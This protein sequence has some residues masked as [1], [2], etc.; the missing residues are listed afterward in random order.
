MPLYNAVN[1]TYR[2]P[3]GISGDVQATVR[4][5]NL[6]VL[7]CPSDPDWLSNSPH[8]I[9]S[10]NRA[11]NYAGNVGSE[12]EDYPETGV[13]T[14][15]S[16]GPRDITDGLSQTAG[17]SEWII[18]RGTEF[19]DDTGPNQRG[20]LLG[21][22][23]GIN[24]ES[25]LPDGL[26]AF[27][28]ACTML[29]IGRASVL[30][31]SKGTPWMDSSVGSS[32]YNHVLPPNSPSCNYISESPGSDVGPGTVFFARSAGSRHGG[33][34]QSLLLDG[35]VRFVKSSIDRRAWA[36]LGT[37]AGQEIFDSSAIP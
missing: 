13:F 1:F 6:A 5:A 23:W 21:S 12:P 32:R 17:V 15:R 7:L 14:G 16:I 10:F 28:R 37:R 35:S 33:G 8:E 20:D 19:R 4:G 11:T 22:I 24:Y 26:D 34:I 3:D 27:A 30:V 2:T 9:I 25:I 36:A 31:A 18:G 29:D